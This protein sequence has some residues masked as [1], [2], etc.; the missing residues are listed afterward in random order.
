MQNKSDSKVPEKLVLEEH[1]NNFGEAVIAICDRE[2]NYQL[3]TQAAYQRIRQMWLQL[4][5]TQPEI[6]DYIQHNYIKKQV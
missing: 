3:S 6:T 4:R 1:L 5:Q 2:E